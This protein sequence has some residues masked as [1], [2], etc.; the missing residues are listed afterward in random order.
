MNSS[1][2]ITAYMIH[3]RTGCTCCSYDNHFSG[4]FSSKDVA[5][6]IKNKFHNAKKLASQYAP[7]GLYSIYDCQAELLPDGRIIIESRIFQGWA[8]DNPWDAIP[9][10]PFPNG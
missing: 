1:T 2:T 9:V 8:D 7:N 10:D 4:P 6:T 3:A 5:E